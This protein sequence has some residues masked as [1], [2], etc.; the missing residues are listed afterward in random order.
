MIYYLIYISEATCLMDAAELNDILSNA[1]VNNPEK[2]ITGMLLY[3]EGAFTVTGQKHLHQA[4]KGKF[5]QL[6]E[7]SEQGVKDTFKMIKLDERHCNIII[8]KEGLVAQRYFGDWSMGFNRYQ[9][10]DEGELENY[11][12]VKHDFLNQP[13]SSEDK[14]P[15]LFLK[16]FYQM[17][18]SRAIL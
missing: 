14:G 13:M 5:I 15:H 16:S 7:G 6:L 10:N 4:V 1:S 17:A 2:D 8:M 3:I 9:V 18:R 11:S 12:D